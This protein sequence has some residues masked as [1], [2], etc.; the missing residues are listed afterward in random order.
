LQGILVFVT[1]RLVESANKQADAALVA[2]KATQESAKVMENSIKLSEKSLKIQE[3]SMKITNRA[4]ISVIKIEPTKINEFINKKITVKFLNSGQTPA[5]KAE[6]R[7]RISLVEGE[8]CPR[9]PTSLPE[10][11]L[12]EIIVGKSGVFSITR[13][14]TLTKPQIDA[15]K[16]K[17]LFLNIIGTVEYRDVFNRSQWLKYQMFYNVDTEAYTY[18]KEHNEAS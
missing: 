2:A 11:V 12:S 17:K 3:K 7:T 9:L 6:T 13:K 10:H 14:A 15:I 18:C 1:W 5:Y 16:M 4:Y 8:S